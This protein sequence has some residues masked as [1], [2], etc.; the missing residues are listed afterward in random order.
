MERPDD[1]KAATQ[2]QV[3]LGGRRIDYRVVSSTAARNLRVRVGP[4]G[5]EVVQPATRNGEDLSA[6]LHRHED[7]ILDQLRR[8]DRLRNT[9]VIRRFTAEIEP[10]A[11]GWTIE[12]FV[13]VYCEG[14]VPPDRMREMVSTIP[15][16]AEAYGRAR[17]LCDRA[18]DAHSLFMVLFGLARFDWVRGHLNTARRDAEELLKYAERAGDQNA[19]RLGQ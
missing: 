12:A 17:T 5:I 6:F 18:G 10:A 1:M 15:E 19:D 8:V 7:W 13:E 14:R 16:V 11:L 2:N 4:G 3:Q 9:G